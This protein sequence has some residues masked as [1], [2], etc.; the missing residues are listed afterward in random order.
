MTADE[1]KSGQSAEITGFKDSVA[2][3]KLLEFGFIPGKVVSMTF[4]APLGD[5]IALELA[6]SLVSMRKDE[7]R[8][9]IVEPIIES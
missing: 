3:R 2:R 5:P 1:L 9:L 7:A 8:A 6:G 4:R